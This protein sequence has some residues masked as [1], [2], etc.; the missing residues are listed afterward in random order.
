MLKRRACLE[1][2][3]AGKQA[4]NDDKLTLGQLG[5]AT[6]YTDNQIIDAMQGSKVVKPVPGYYGNDRSYKYVGAAQN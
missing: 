5:A 4:R 3:L 2:K 1:G 6:G